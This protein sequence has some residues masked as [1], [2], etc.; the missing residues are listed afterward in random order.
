[1]FLFLKFLKEVKL[2]NYSF[3]PQISREVDVTRDMWIIS[4]H[5]SLYTFVDIIYG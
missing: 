5:G 4:T 2:L 3:F 1:M